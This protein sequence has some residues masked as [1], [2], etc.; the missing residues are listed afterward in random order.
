MLMAFSTI[1]FLATT[2]AVKIHVLVHILVNSGLGKKD[3][4]YAQKIFYKSISDA[5]IAFVI[6]V[7][8]CIEDFFLELVIISP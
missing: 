1:W 6:Y 5:T 3:T 7:T 2:D 8:N 4:L